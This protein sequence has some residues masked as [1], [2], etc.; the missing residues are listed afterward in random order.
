MPQFSSLENED[1]N[2]T[3][4]SRVGINETLS[5][6][7]AKCLE[8]GVHGRLAAEL[9]ADVIRVIVKMRCV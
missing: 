1:N 4:G 5:T 8:Q 3:D 6:K 7:T 2:S 9:F